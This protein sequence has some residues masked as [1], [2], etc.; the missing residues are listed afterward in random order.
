M[1]PG[2][3]MEN[4]RSNVRE[5]LKRSAETKLKIGVFTISR[6]AVFGVAIA[7][8]VM[9]AFALIYILYG[10]QETQLYLERTPVT[11]PADYRVDDGILS[12]RTDSSLET[13]Y[14]KSSKEVDSAKLYA[15]I[16]GYDVS[17]TLTILYAGNAVQVRG[18]Q[19]FSLSAGTISDVRAGKSHAA[20]LFRNPAGENHIQLLDSDGVSLNTI[21]LNDSTVVAFDFLDAG[22]GR[23]LLWVSTLDVGQ[24]TEESLVRIY[25]C[26]RKGTL[27]F[28]SASF[29]NQTVYDVYLSEQCLFLVGTQDIVRYHREDDGGF[30][31]EKDR[32][33]VF[34]STV[35]DFAYVE[36]SAYFITIPHI[37]DGTNSHLFRLLTI[38]QTD[39]TW[40]TVM[41][42]HTASP[43]VG[44]FL[45]ESQIRV[46]TKE[47][48]TAYSYTGAV[49]EQ[50]ELKEFPSAAYRY[51]DT[52]FL[53]LTETECFRA[54]MK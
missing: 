13:F 35:V 53:F 21:L 52:E 32:I 2:K 6:L 12:Y 3:N 8:L 51:S 4:F 39:D 31:S 36:E 37:G 43:I 54:Y 49:R 22:N 5:Y 20:V 30:T 14:G 50:I 24:F 34:G 47:S 25:D 41:Q 23:E 33:A 45:M 16:D 19:G 46:L 28:Y 38:S 7:I 15:S 26:D 18:R 27:L 17:E 48:F 42:V 29:Y 10:N 40:A 11:L 1:D 9:A 44:A